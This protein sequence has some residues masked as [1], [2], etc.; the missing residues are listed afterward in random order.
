MTW[1]CLVQSSCTRPST[2]VVKTALRQVAVLAKGRSEVVSF[3]TMR[4]SSGTYNCGA[5][6]SH[7]GIA[8][9]QDNAVQLQAHT[10]GSHPQVLSERD[11]KSLSIAVNIRHIRCMTVLLSNNCLQVADV[12]L[13]PLQCQGCKGAPPGFLWR[14]M[15]RHRRNPLP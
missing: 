4:S 10:A 1:I 8:A 6:G 14:G 13:K 7:A 3:R 5:E 11:P 9:M 12:A 2:R 15:G